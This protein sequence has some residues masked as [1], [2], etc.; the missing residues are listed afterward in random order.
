MTC[1]TNPLDIVSE[2]YPYYCLWIE[3]SDQGITKCQ[4]FRNLV[5]LSE[6]V[7]QHEADALIGRFSIIEMGQYGPKP[8]RQHWL[9]YSTSFRGALHALDQ[10]SRLDAIGYK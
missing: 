7:D 9:I 5:R 4:S 2:T 8:L 3:G 10:E 1:N 6:F